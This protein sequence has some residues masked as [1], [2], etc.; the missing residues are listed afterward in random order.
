MA[1]RQHKSHA[2]AV[3]LAGDVMSPVG[4]LTTNDDDKPTRR[5]R[6]DAVKVG[7]YKHPHDGW[8]EDFDHDRMDRWCA[9]FKKMRDNGVDVEFFADHGTPG[10]RIEKVRGYIEDMYRDGDDLMVVVEMSGE[11]GI[12]IAGSCRNVSIE[13]DEFTDAKGNDYGEAIVAVVACE[14]PVVP[15]QRP[16]ERIAASRT[17]SKPNRKIPILTL[18][19]DPPEVTDMTPLLEAIGKAIGADDITEDNAAEKL[20]AFGTSHTEQADK[21]KTLTDQL[22]DLESKAGKGKLPEVDEDLLE[23]LADPREAELDALVVAGNIT[24]AARNKLAA[25]IIGEPGKRR[26][27]TLSIKVAKHFG[28]VTS[29]TKQIIDALKENDPAVLMKLREKTG[30]QRLTLVRDSGDDDHNKQAGERTKELIESANKNKSASTAI[31]I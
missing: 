26:A 25:A 22:A 15:G 23:E 8:T 7:T 24:P 12:K 2:F 11:D 29:L 30:P 4:S 19:A 27:L 1:K 6:K 3:A 10:D 20:L 16:F 31:A 9:A 21:V 18:A 28:F 17:G 5:F 14:K 13:L